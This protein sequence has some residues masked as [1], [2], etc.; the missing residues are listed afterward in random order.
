MPYGLQLGL[1]AVVAFLIG[2][3][4]FSLYIARA[5]AGI[6]LRKHGSGNVGATNVARTVGWKWGIAA[7][8]LDATKGV[9]PT[10]LLPWLMSEPS[11]AL[12]HER[13]LCGAAAVMGHMFSPWLG[14]RGGKG[15]ATA[16]GVVAVLAPVA[17]GCAFLVFVLT[18][19]FSRIVALSSI[20]AAVTYGVAEFLFRGDVL[21]SREG[22][23]LGVFAVAIPLLII[24]RHRSNLVRLWNGQET[25][26]QLR[27]KEAAPQDGDSTQA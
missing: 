13:T 11:P 1:S 23:G 15:V 21:S 7:L 9:L 14:F 10:L 19:I 25:R 24:F 22:W 8:L 5:V 6:D 20:L 12:F 4:P 18:F 17:T 16:L 27:K 3:I 2:S 26:L